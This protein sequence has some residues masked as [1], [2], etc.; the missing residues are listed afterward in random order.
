MGSS[1]AS[2]ASVDSAFSKCRGL[3]PQRD[4]RP[5]ERT[6]HTD[7]PEMRASKA[8]DERG[9]PGPAP[10]GRTDYRRCLKADAPGPAWPVNSTGS[11]ATT[12]PPVAGRPG[13][14]E[15]IAWSQLGVA[16]A[17]SS[18]PAVGGLATAIAGYASPS[19]PNEVE[20]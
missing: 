7:C 17:Q 1:F 10:L 11:A 18:P 6:S 4:E 9:R 19:E 3:Q 2:T 12:L 8:I 15:Y 20:M 14:L 13:E 5:A 16:L